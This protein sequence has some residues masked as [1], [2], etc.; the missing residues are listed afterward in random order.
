MVV[1]IGKAITDRKAQ[2]GAVI[3][4]CHVIPRRTVTELCSV[5]TTY[6]LA[7]P[8]DLAGLQKREKMEDF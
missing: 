7:K 1:K 2:N 6:A 8:K 3:I 4:F 5:P